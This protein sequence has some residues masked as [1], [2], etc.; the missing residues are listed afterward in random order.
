MLNLPVNLMLLFFMLVLKY[1][2]N[3]LRNQGKKQL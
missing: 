3:I 2:F 1:G